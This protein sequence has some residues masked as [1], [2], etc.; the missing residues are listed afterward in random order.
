[1]LLALPA[2][3]EEPQIQWAATWADAFKE[4]KAVNRPV[5]VCINGRDG[6][7][8]NEA[9]AFQIYRDPVFV[10]LT[11]RF[12][13]VLVSAREHAAEGPCPRFGGITCQQHLDCWK[14]LCAAHE[15]EFTSGGG[16]M[17]SPQH[18]WFRPDGKLIVRR[19]Y[20][21][22]KHEL[23]RRMRSALAA[24]GGPV[25]SGS[26]V[27]LDDADRAAL[28]RLENATD[29]AGR[30]AAMSPLLAADK[31]AAYAALRELLENARSIELRTELLRALVLSRVPGLRQTAEK[32]LTDRD[33]VVRSA[34]AVAL[35][36]MAEKE[37]VPALVKRV[38]AESDVI[39]RRNVC[40]ALAACGGPGA[41]KA[42][43]RALLGVVTSDK[44]QAVRRHAAYALR[45]FAGDGADLVRRR[46][47]LAAPQAKDKEVRCAIAYALAFVGDP[48]T[49]PPVL[50]KLLE[51][52]SNPWTVEFLRAA[53]GRVGVAV[54]EGE[55][56]RL[57][58]AATYLIR[59]DRDDPARAD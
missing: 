10:A 14:D 37:A 26:A 33:A 59:E 30:A 48:K 45:A 3:A 15:K 4:A 21:L 53:L 57:A 34:A 35:E 2:V 40:R 56:D 5:M 32:L 29:R 13:M 24:V 31:A 43:A 19:E 41:D 12:T 27:P 36:D 54:P 11:H 18:A 55:E 17:I 49:T 44:E 6:E 9:T 7:S 58:T 50:E 22:S 16:D 46:L 8:A 20:F 42:A 47:E 51:K 38:R 25:A 52:E 28:E 23:M 39:A 1:V